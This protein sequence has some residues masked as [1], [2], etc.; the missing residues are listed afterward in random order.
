MLTIKKVLSCS[1]CSKAFV[2][3]VQSPRDISLPLALW[4]EKASGEKVCHC[5]YCG[6]VWVRG[7]SDVAIGWFN[8]L[9]NPGTFV[10]SPR[11]L[12]PVAKPSKTPQKTYRSGKRFPK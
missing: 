4:A 7:Q 1:D 8:S 5:R 3:E 2:S 9:S 12:L 10:P 6:L 11:R